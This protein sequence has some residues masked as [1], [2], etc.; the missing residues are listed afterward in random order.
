M[1]R[2]AFIISLR[3]PTSVLA[4]IQIWIEK[5]A[6]LILILILSVISIASYIHYYNNGLGLAYNDARSHLDIGRRVVEGLKP[7]VDQLGSVWLP[8]THVLMALTIWN[9]FMWHS[10]LAGAIWSMMAFVGTGVLVYLFLKRLKIGLLGRFIGVFVF[11]ANINILYLQSTAMT[12]LVLLVT[13]TAGAYQLLIWSQ[14]QKYVHLV[15]A[16]FWIMLST[17]VRYDGWFLLAMATA[18]IALYSWRR[19]SY[20][21]LEGT[22]VMFVTLASLGVG[23]WLIWNLIIFG[24]P[25]FFAFGEY[26]AHSQQQQ[27]EEAGD[28]GT[29]GNW[30]FSLRV[31]FYALVYNSGALPV[32]LGAIGAIVLWLDKRVPPGVRLV[33]TVLFAPLLFNI[34]ALYL[35]HSVL[36]V[37]GLSG[38]AWFNVRYGVMMMPS[39][40]IFIGYLAHRVSTLRIPIIGLL[41]MTAFFTFSSVDAVTVDDALFGSSQKN[42]SEV[43]GWLKDNT[44]DQPGFVLISAASHDAVIFSS[45]LPMKKFIHEGTGLYWEKA[46]TEPEKWARWIVVRTHSENDSTWRLIKD[47]SGLQRYDLVAEDQFA[48]V[49][50]LQAEYLNE[51]ET[52]PSL[53]KQK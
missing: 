16:A 36:S 26:S 49:Y 31:Y 50:Q 6:I 7:G 40:A 25:L 41:L 2:E 20:G 13:M 18:I 5:Y 45:G 27:L 21:R 46:T 10:G 30:L 32:L 29:K 22:V 44:T 28:L 15:G 42:V 9:D 52:K 34:L 11:I 53:G 38:D 51:V 19:W 39:V 4:R 17:L 37:Q 47:A 48:D 12:E 23:L 3:W 24:D 35:G 14:N 43:S 33:T 8:L 1:N